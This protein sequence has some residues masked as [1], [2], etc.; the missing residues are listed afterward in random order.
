[1]TEPTALEQVTALIAAGEIRICRGSNPIS[2]R[3]AQL[4]LDFHHQL[5]ELDEKET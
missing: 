1:M 5:H 4:I 3:E 2:E